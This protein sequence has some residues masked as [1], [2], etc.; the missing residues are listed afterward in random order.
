MVE[1]GR[2]TTGSPIADANASVGGSLSPVLGRG[3]SYSGVLDRNA[4][5]EELAATDQPGYT[6]CLFEAVD[7]AAD[8]LRMGSALPRIKSQYCMW[9]VMLIDIRIA[10]GRT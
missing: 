9:S 1:R 4:D 10:S 8:S 2:G 3:I 5:L 6:L 7:F